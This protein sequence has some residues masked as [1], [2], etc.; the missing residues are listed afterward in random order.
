MS[1]LLQTYGSLNNK[2]EH[3]KRGKEDYEMAFLY[4][5][6]VLSEVFLDFVMI[7]DRVIR[8]ID[9]SHDKRVPEGHDAHVPK[10]SDV[11]QC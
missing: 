3:R 1:S 5:L 10:R 4:E 9:H 7:T 11:Q 6:V 2:K 8:L